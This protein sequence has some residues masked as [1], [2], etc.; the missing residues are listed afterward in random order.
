M[1]RE[2][3][4]KLEEGRLTSGRLAS[5][6]S[7]GP[8]GVFFVH[9]PCGCE[10]K[11]I[12]SG[13]DETGW[14]HVSVSTPR[15]PPNWQEMCFVKELFWEPDECV[16]QFHPPESQ[17]VNNHPHCLHLWRSI[18]EAFPLPPA[19]LVG[20]KSAGVLPLRMDR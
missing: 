4:A 7:F 9:G 20:V 3:P 5:D 19:I 10:L 13:G 11:I 14:E 12:A 16:V 6:A 17:Y 15:R 8:Y 2:L 18:R 1:R